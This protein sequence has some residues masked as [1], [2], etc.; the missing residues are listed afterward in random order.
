MFNTLRQAQSAFSHLNPATVRAH[1]TRPVRV[2]LIASSPAGYEAME[3]L[4]VP[5]AAPT[6]ERHRGLS[7]LYRGGDPHAPP[8]VELVLYEQGIPT[9]RGTFVLY[10]D[11]PEV[12]VKDI[13]N[14]FPDFELPLARQF[15]GLRK[16]VVERIVST[17]ARENTMFAITTALPDIIPSFIELPWAFGEWASDTAF[18]TANEIRMAFMIAG[19]CGGEIGFSHQKAQV[20]SIGAGAFGLRALARELA[21]KIPLG[22]GLIAKGAIAFAGTY[23][24]GKA[25]ALAEHGNKDYS[26]EEKRSLY[27]QAYER[28]RE[29]AHSLVPLSK[30]GLNRS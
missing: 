27:R 8:N 23:V 29:V 11:D 3:E 20:L 7:F 10:R 2:G 13:C 16:L 9:P 18:L 24:M 4:L 22:G 15:P 25:L 21:G 1:A 5:A 17:V 12:T 28:G 19:A 30:A 14:E 6:I 26:H